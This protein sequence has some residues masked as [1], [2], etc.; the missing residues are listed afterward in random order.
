M[1][2]KEFQ[3]FN[4]LFNDLFYGLKKEFF[5]LELLDSYEIDPEDESHESFVQFKKGNVVI[6]EWL[7]ADFKDSETL[8]E[9]D[10]R[11]IR[12][13]IVSLP[14]SDYLRWEI[15]TSY[16]PFIEHG[17]D[18][19]LISRN[20]FDQYALTIVDD[21]VVIDDESVVVIKY[22]EQGRW[23]G[24]EGPATEDTV[25]NSMVSLKNYLLSKALPLEEF[26]KSH[27]IEV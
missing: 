24:Y 20:E 23:L 22:D 1:A 11:E 3:E 27:N 13:H 5:H 14:L 2:E 4:E 8:R 16:R 18:V 10:I 17:V 25:V 21:F 26:L 7:N 6:P 9:K 12:L 19:F 15:A